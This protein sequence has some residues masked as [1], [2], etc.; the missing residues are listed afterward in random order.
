MMWLSIVLVGVSW[1]A[2]GLLVT[3]IFRNTSKDNE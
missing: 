1:M 2:A 3:R